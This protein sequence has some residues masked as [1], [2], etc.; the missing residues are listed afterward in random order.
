M[1]KRSSGKLAKNLTNDYQLTVS[2]DNYVLYSQSVDTYVCYPLYAE[3]TLHML[4]Q[5]VPL[6]ILYSM[7]N[8]LSYAETSS[9]YHK[10]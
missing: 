3:I 2:S 9:E 1:C 10:Q 5:S 6:S 4:V 8:M 7:L